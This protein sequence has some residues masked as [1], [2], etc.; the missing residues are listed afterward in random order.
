MPLTAQRQG[1]TVTEARLR[2]DREERHSA[3]GNEGPAGI[4]RGGK[5][6]HAEKGNVKKIAFQLHAASSR[7]QACTASATFCNSSSVIEVEQGKVTM[8]FHSASVRVRV[9][10]GAET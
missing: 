9:A 10:R 1:G 6:E 7:A 8:R 2:R 3:P 5:K 4:E